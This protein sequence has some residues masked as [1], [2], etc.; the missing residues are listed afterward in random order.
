[1]LAGKKVVNAM[2]VNVGHVHHSVKREKQNVHVFWNT[3]RQRL[4][5]FLKHGKWSRASPNDRLQGQDLIAG[6]HM[7][8]SERDTAA[9]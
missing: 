7:R 9:P 1:M 3:G 6:S 2:Y 5:E 8:K 4:R